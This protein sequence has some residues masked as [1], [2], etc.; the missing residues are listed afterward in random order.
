[1]DNLY[2]QEIRVKKAVPFGEAQ[3]MAQLFLRSKRKTFF[4]VGQTEYHFRNI[5]RTKFKWRSLRKCKV[6]E[7]VSLIY[8]KLKPRPG[9]DEPMG[10]AN[11]PSSD[12]IQGD[13]DSSDG[14]ENSFSDSDTD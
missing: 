9:T 12:I 4:S 7:N 14:S 8:G 5:P 6:S 1:M 11:M 10:S 2:L 13:S 3:K